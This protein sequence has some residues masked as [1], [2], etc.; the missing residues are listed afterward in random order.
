MSLEFGAKRAR[1]EESVDPVISLVE[2]DSTAMVD[3]PTAVVDELVNLFQ[4]SHLK[5]GEDVKPL[6]L[7]FST[8]PL[9]SSA[10]PADAADA[11]ARMM[12]S[13]DPQPMGRGRPLPLLLSLNELPFLEPPKLSR[14]KATR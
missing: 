7:D 10:V 14:K 8:L 6:S 11:F 9:F 13:S 12:L 3:E 4:F 5:S 2:G 1:K